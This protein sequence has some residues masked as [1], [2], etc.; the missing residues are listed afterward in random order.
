MINSP[1]MRPR[2]PLLRSGR[3]EVPLLVDGL[4]PNP[5]NSRLIYL[6]SA[7]NQNAQHE[8]KQTNK[9]KQTQRTTTHTHQLPNDQ[10][11]KKQQQKNTQKMRDLSLRETKRT[12]S[13]GRACANRYPPVDPRSSLSHFTFSLCTSVP[14]FFEKSKIKG[15]HRFRMH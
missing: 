13:C 10:S 5:P 4:L 3:S 8:I 1:V 12:S 7:K 6:C 14:L 9:Q 2:H 15:Y 11:S